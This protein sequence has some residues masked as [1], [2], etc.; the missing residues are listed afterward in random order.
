MPKTLSN[1]D[2]P[3]L[4]P[5]RLIAGG[6]PDHRLFTGGLADWIAA[7][8]RRLSSWVCVHASEIGGAS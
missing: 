2:R 8:E 6:N 3:T 1:L 5:A 4:R 7:P